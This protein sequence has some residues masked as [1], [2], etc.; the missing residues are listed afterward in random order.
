MRN[1]F[2]KYRLEIIVFAIALAARLLFFSASFEAHGHNIVETIKGDDGYYEASQNFIH[3]HGFSYSSAPPYAP[4]PLRPPVWLFIIAAIAGIFKS[5]WAVFIFEVLIG[6]FIPVLGMIIV[7]KLFAQKAVWLGTGV[8]LALEPYCVMLSTLLYSETMFTFFFLLFFLFLI[9]YFEDKSY[10]SLAWVS[11][12]MGLA[13]LVKPTIQYI[14]IVLALFIIFEARKSL[15]KKTFA[16]ALVMLGVF[17]AIIA[18]WIVRNYVEFG[19]IGMSAQPAFNLYIYLVP[20]VLSIDNHT[21]FKTELDSFVYKKGFDVSDITLATSDR[22]SS[23]AMAIIREHKL[24]LAKSV[25]TTIVTFFTHDGMLT[26]L[27]Y[28]GKTIV[29]TLDKPALTILIES[30]AKLFSIIGAYVRSGAAIIVIMR[31]VWIM[32]T[33]SFFAGAAAYIRREGWRPAAS[34]ALFLVI[35]FAL[36]TSINGLG[37][38]AR[39]RVP[40]D[41][42][43]FSFALY[44]LLLARHTILG[45]LKR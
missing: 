44:G 23:E 17:G 19:K 21:N 4:N 36:T 37:V 43:I 24:A 34:A 9:K 5:Y 32:V 30:P 16:H 2:L 28:A 31:L 39:F 22:Y 6:S 29:N 13:T 11:V 14:P 26:F 27:A 1:F 20:T 12:F 38:N 3:G 40:V 35:Y 33:I 25:A 42:F 10:R 41:A 7:R 8:L 18:P 45:K 15:S